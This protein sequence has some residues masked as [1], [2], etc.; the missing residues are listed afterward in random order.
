ML[1]AQQL[2]DEFEESTLE[3]IYDAYAT[4]FKKRKPGEKGY[5]EYQATVERSKERDKQYKQYTK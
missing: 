2:P 5:E 3:N 1:R 4:M